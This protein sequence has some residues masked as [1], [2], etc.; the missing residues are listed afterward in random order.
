[1]HF[2]RLNGDN[3]MEYTLLYTAQSSKNA[4]LSVEKQH[5]Y[6]YSETGYMFQI[7]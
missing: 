2:Y 4:K 1:M 3:V 7:N 5:I 6:I